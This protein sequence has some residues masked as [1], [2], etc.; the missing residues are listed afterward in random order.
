VKVRNALNNTDQ[1]LFNEGLV[2]LKACFRF[3]AITTIIM[4]MLYVLARIYRIAKDVI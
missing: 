4:M 3:W 1:D 2:K